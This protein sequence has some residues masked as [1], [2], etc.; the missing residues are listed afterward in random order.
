MTANRVDVR[1]NRQTGLIEVPPGHAVRLTRIGYHASPR[2]QALNELVPARKTH[3]FAL[4]P[5]KWE[6][7]FYSL[8]N[9][10]SRKISFYQPE[11]IPVRPGTLIADMYW[12]NQFLRGDDAAG[13]LYQAGVRPV[14]DA[15]LADYRMLELLIPQERVA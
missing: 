11:A 7:T 3:A 12:A 8:T 13:G 2:D 6:P 4:H 14:E 15:D 1:Y 5:D 10:E 9:K